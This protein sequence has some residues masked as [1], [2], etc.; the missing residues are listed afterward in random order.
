[1][2]KVAKKYK[3]DA[4]FFVV[5]I[6]EAH[7]ADSAWPEPI[8]GEEAIN[9]PKTYGERVTIANKCYKKLN[10]KIPCLIDDI[11]NSTEQA[12]EAWPERIFLVDTDG[13]IAV[14]AER[15]PWGFAP[16]LKKA[17]NW[18]KKQFPEAGS[19]SAEADKN[20]EARDAT[21]G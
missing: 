10:I 1:M 7:A 12:Y 4:E 15:G 17:R 20:I 2:N 16:G 11:D 18:L 13:K 9:T 6:R 8:E 19:Q 5:Y 14:R 3:D 21:Q